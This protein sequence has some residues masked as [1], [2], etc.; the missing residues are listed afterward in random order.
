[1]V[2]QPSL[3]PHIQM[4]CDSV[5]VSSTYSSLSVVTEKS[6]VKQSLLRKECIKFI[7]TICSSI[8]V[9]AAEEGL[10]RC[11]TLPLPPFQYLSLCYVSSLAC[12]T[13]NDGV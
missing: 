4:V 10:L 12:A 1:M 9:N 5:D 6:P 8:G 2:V 3:H 13:H 7:T 11:V